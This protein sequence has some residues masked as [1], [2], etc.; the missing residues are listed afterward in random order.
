MKNSTLLLFAAFFLSSTV[1]FSQ[2]DTPRPSPKGSLTQDIGLT[3]I[4]VEYSRPSVKDR[5]IFGDLVPYGEMWRTGANASTKV[6]VNADVKV[7]GEE[8]K[9]GE[10]AL[11]TVPGDSEWTII[12]YENTS[13]WGTPGKEYTEDNVAAKIRVK[14]TRMSDFVETFTINVNNLRNA[15]ADLELMWERTKVVIPIGLNTDEAV[16]AEIKAKIDGPSA[17]TYYS[18]ARYYY[19]ENKDLNLALAWVQMAMDKSKEEQFWV[20]RLK[21][22]ILGKIGRYDEA[23]KT[24]EHSTSLAK[25]ANNANYPKMNAKSIAEW[26]KMK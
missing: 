17:D 6:K 21:A 2:I 9:R 4:E 25:K 10:Y 24:A 22:L 13:Y 8:L 12:F 20:V 26:Q 7:G 15:S 5:V 23:I 16:M 3:S 11:Y 19:E 14:P 18:A 1:A